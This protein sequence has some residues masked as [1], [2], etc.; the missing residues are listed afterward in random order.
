MYL[1][2]EYTDFE[3]ITTL[4]NN[5]IFRQTF[6][7]NGNL[8][9]T[10]Y[11]KN[12]TAFEEQLLQNLYDAYGNL[13]LVRDLKDGEKLYKIFLQRRVNSTRKHYNS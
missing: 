11:K 1:K 12:S 7:K 2:K 4:G 3:E 10:F 6:D 5:E 9:D 13:I 8:I